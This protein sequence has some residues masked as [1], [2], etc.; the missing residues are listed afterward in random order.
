[1]KLKI[2]IMKTRPEMTDDEIRAYMNFDRLLEMQKKASVHRNFFDTRYLLILLIG[3]GIGIFS[4]IKIVD[5]NDAPVQ[6][7][8]AK[9]EKKND[10]VL[11]NN[12]HIPIIDSTSKQT[13]SEVLTKDE[14]PKSQNSIQKQKQH[15]AHTD[16]EQPVPNDTLENNI[17]E[18][19]SDREKPTATLIYVQAAPVHGY[20]NL[21]EYFNRELKYPQ[22]AMKDSIQGEVIAVFTINAHGLAE[23]ILIENSLGPLFDREVVRL[24]A[25]MP[26]WKPA[27]YNNKPV[28][29]KMSLP[30]TFQIKKIPS[31][32]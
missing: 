2:K 3:V 15:T 32:K 22:D 30:L 5:T 14:T 17:H 21:Y 26:P 4:W 12:T 24:I 23:K 1:M 16:V 10:Q 7:P 27:T 29:S 18:V 11:H 28:A 31:Q 13:S 25:N 6:E 8:V 19:Q 20:P 9:A